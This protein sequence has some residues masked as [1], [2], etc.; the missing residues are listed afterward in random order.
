M[1]LYSYWMAAVLLDVVGVLGG[2]FGVAFSVAWVARARAQNRSSF[3]P[4]GWLNSSLPD[5]E[6]S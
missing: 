1:A 5:L 2:V 4:W 6:N 3:V